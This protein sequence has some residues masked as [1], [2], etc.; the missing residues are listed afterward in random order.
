MDQV[1]HTILC[2]TALAE[3]A[4]LLSKMIQIAE[5]RT[6]CHGNGHVGRSA[7]LTVDALFS[8]C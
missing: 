3:R 7:S 5:V 1:V 6:S 8:C 4:K 2:E